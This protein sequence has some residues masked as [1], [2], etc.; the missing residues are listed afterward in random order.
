MATASVNVGTKVLF[1]ADSH[2]MEPVDLWKKGVPVTMRD[3]APVF[4]PHKVGEGFQSQ[5]GGWDPHER[6]KE[7]AQD[8]VSAEVLYPTLGLGLFA[9]DDPKMQAACF[10]VYN[11]WIADY[12]AVA[13][14]R[15]LGV[16]MIATH[17]IKTAVAELERSHKA[18]LR[19]A[20]VWQTPRP[21][22]PFKSGHYDALW[23]A[24]EALDMPVSLHILTGH[25]Y[26]KEQFE[27]IAR[28]EKLEG[29]DSYRNS[30][31]TKHYEVANAVLELIFSGALERFPKLKVVIVE[32]EAGWI[33]FMLQ[34]WD[35]YYNRFKTRNPMPIT[36]R[37]SEYF[38]R[39]GYATFFKDAVA[40][41]SFRF[42][43]QDNCMWSND[44]PH[45]NTTWPNSVQVI[46]DTLGH[47][48]EDTL[49][50]LLYENAERL[51][52]IQVTPIAP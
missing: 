22:L 25:G 49:R 43:G 31:N 5:S 35:Y 30:V 38:D 23:E 48:P 39:Q 47:L 9:L 13:P 29:T 16:G 18:G 32:N 40:G 6:Q 36:M 51:Y 12:C 2:V 3:E 7:M 37:P 50:K 28:G 20:L 10:E 19:G 14:D 44:F 21:D 34:Q 26:S 41:Q 52:G 17:D 4:P 33:P 8:N 11:D 42:W 46:E 15:L 1:S 24:A 27:R 45:E